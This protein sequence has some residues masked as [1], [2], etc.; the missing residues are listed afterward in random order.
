[1]GPLQWGTLA[2]LLWTVRQ[3]VNL[4]LIQITPPDPL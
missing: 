3:Q 1:M 2:G 4:T